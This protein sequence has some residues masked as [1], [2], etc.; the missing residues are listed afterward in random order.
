MRALNDEFSEADTAML[1]LGGEPAR[2]R[3]FRSPTRLPQALAYIL[4]QADMP[5][6]SQ[7]EQARLS[8]L[9]LAHRGKL[10]KIEDLPEQSADWALI[11]A[12]SLAAL[13]NLSRRDLALPIPTARPRKAASS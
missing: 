5:G 11:F 1:R 2:D 7:K 13:F 8:R 3:H 10:T 12:L 9:V 4:A 6:F